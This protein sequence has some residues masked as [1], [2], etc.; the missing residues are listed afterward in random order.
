MDAK[1]A[2]EPAN[3]DKGNL[4]NA[5]AEDRAV[6]VKAKG[7]RENLKVVRLLVVAH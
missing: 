1:L 3:K 2:T 7:K 4:N 6:A 5:I